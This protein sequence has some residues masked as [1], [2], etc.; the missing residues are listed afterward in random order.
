MPIV[1]LSIV[2]GAAAQ[3][4]DNNGVPLSGGKFYTYV[5][6]TNTP[7]ATYTSSSGTVAHANPIVLDSAGRVP[8]GEIW[9]DYASQYKFVLKTSAEVLIGTYNNIGG[10]FTGSPITATFT[11]NGS[12]TVFTLPS[13]PA[14]L[15]T[16]QVYVSGVYQQKST[17]TVASTT[18]TFSEAPPNS[19]AIEVVYT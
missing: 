8:G 16:T 9:L 18:L 5:A 6:S 14:G 11:G 3:M 2:A 10:S 7:L 13:S 1:T 12:T 19:A 4:F 15:A 17:Y